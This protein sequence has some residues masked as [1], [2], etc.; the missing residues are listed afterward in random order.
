METSNSSW[1]LI[2]KPQ[3]KW[4]DLH[5]R[6]LWKYRDLVYLF[7]KRDFVT[8]YKQTILGPAWLII[9]PLIATLMYTVVFGNIAG[10]ST[11]GLPQM[12]FYMAGTITWEYFSQCLLN[13]S[14]TFQANANIFGKVYFP[15]LAIPFSITLSQLLKFA[16]QFLFFMAFWLYFSLNNAEISITWAASLFPLL[17]LIMAIQALGLGILIS[18]LTTKYRDVQNLMTFGV[19]MAMYATTVVYPLS[20]MLEGSTKRLFILANPMTPVIETFRFGF[21]GTGT[22]SWIHLSYSAASGLI[23]IILGAIVFNRVEKNFMDTV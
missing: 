14:A 9:N 17:V 23:L 10:L 12:L 1:D 22:F 3:S 8:L 15:R 13:T 5:L 21:L 7:V 18:A 20:S 16:L 19:R 2:I 6:E 11:D 4:F